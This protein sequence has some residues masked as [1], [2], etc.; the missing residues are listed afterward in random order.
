MTTT[1]S[2]AAAALSGLFLDTAIE[3]RRTHHTSWDLVMACNSCLTGLVAIS[4]GSQVVSTWASVLIGTLAGWTY[5][6]VD[7]LLLRLRIDDAVG[8]IQ[9]HLGGGILGMLS[10]GLFANPYYLNLAGFNSAHSGWFYSWGRSSGDANLLLCEFCLFL[11]IVTWVSI[12]MVPFYMI[13]KATDQ[14]RVHPDVEKL[15]CDEYQHRILPM[16]DEPVASDLDPDED[17]EEYNDRKGKELVVD[18][19]E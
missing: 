16:P 2:A 15:G 13:L 19:A 17:E 8:A 6:A 5:Y 9:V 3:R 12:L 18:Y 14:L 10:T 4:G 1:L 11:Y 7:K